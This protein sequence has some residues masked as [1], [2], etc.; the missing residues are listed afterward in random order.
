M[1]V[2]RALRLLETLATPHDVDRYLE[3]VH[4][5][6]TVRE[7]RAV[8]V[9]VDR[10]TPGSVV[11]TLRPNRRW[12][13][14]AAG[15]YVQVAF[16]IDG[17]RHVR[18]YSPCSS[19]HRPDGRI[20]LTVRAHEHGRASR[21]LARQARPGLVVGLS[22]ADGT[23]RLPEPRPERIVLISAGSGITPV[24]SMLRTLVDEDHRGT[25][26]F[27]HYARTEAEVAH[28]AELRR[29]A[30]R[31]HN[32]RILFGFTRQSAAGDLAGRFHAAH[33][34]AAPWY[35]DAHTYLCGPPSLQN[36]VRDHYRTLG[37]AELLHVEQFTLRGTI[38]AP[39]EEAT[40]I[41]RFGELAVPNSGGTLLEQAEAAG[42]HPDYGCR[43][44]ICFTCPR[45]KIEGCTRNVRTGELS[46]EPDTEVQLCISAPVG[47]V[48]IEL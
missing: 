39:T 42:L 45:T 23:F 32:M 38:T 24:L 43:M 33:L 8:V 17:V 40:G 20:E 5:M 37:I 7:L 36:A 46:S 44:G 34:S 3:L 9:S 18:C 35:A 11:L 16:A 27:L 15:Q 29:I 4:P 13:G 2:R 10:S 22:P 14:F 26:L 12:P 41:V 31:R 19:Q 48:R 30:A 47:D 28:L 1:A 21:Y 6:L 25:V